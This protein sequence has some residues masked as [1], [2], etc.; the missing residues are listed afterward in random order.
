MPSEHGN[1]H[2]GAGLSQLALDGLEAVA[3]RLVD[4][5]DDDCRLGIDLRDDMPQE[6]H[7]GAVEHHEDDRTVHAR[8]A[9]TGEQLGAATVDVLE[10]ALLDLVVPVRYDIGCTVG[11]EAVEHEVEDACAQVHGDA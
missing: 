8:V 4:A 11:V 2:R 9:T 1:T 7:L 5:G 10:D 6:R 3:K